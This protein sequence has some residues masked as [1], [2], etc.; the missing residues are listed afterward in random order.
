MFPTFFRLSSVDG[1]ST[2]KPHRRKRVTLKQWNLWKQT[3]ESRCSISWISLLK[4]VRS[5]IPDMTGC[6]LGVFMSW[7]P[8][9][10]AKYS[11]STAGRV[12][13]VASPSKTTWLSKPPSAT[14]SNSSERSRRGDN[15]SSSPEPSSSSTPSWPSAGV[16]SPIGVPWGCRWFGWWRTVGI[17][18]FHPVQE[19]SAV[20]WI[21]AWASNTSSWYWTTLAQLGP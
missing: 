10:Q 20:I 12:S 17:L 4:G 5:L 9:V 11:S 21:S 2:E 3:I 14:C 13:G 8:K 19:G 1:R 15:T 16:F 6:G 7:P 18:G